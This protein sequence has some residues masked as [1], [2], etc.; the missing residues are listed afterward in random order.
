MKLEDLIQRIEEVDPDDSPEF[1][2]LKHLLALWQRHKRLVQEAA[3]PD[4]QLAKQKKEKD[5]L[6]RLIRA[7]KFNELASKSSYISGL[8]KG[9]VDLD[10]PDQ[11]RAFDELN[12]TLTSKDGIPEALCELT[13]RIRDYYHQ[14]FSDSQEHK[15]KAIKASDDL[16]KFVKDPQ[17]GGSVSF[18]R[19]ESHLSLLEHERAD[20]L[21]DFRNEPWT[22]A[23]HALVL[24][25][26]HSGPLKISALHATNWNARFQSVLETVFF[27][28]TNPEIRQE[29]LSVMDRECG[30]VHAEMLEKALSDSVRAEDA[31]KFIDEASDEVCKRFMR[32]AVDKGFGKL[33]E[34]LQLRLVSDPSHF[35]FALKKSMEPE[36]FRKVIELL[37]PPGSAQQKYGMDSGHAEKVMRSQNQV[38]KNVLSVLQKGM[39]KGLE[40]ATNLRG[41]LTLLQGFNN[42]CKKTAELRDKI[43][44][45]KLQD[46]AAVALD[47]RAAEIEAIRFVLFTYIYD[48]L[49]IKG[50]N[51]RKINLHSTEVA[52]FL[53]QQL[54]FE[55]EIGKNKNI[56]GFL[57]DLFS[58]HP[59]W[60]PLQPESK[61]GEREVRS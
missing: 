22:P 56:L 30:G 15:E 5:T 37:V 43:D 12:A 1:K 49:K 21:A 40:T 11:R 59:E 34:F 31:K 42:V 17:A 26:R 10:S 61:K 24:M 36:L 38:A 8:L 57:G 28:E 44:P 50:G 53:E 35:Y 25:S 16:K 48:A 9:D 58:S 3:A 32:E 45:G 2:E 6:N 54:R 23:L 4:K 29:L 18:R 33:F 46:H 47:I 52:N 19:F 39:T 51:L 20:G 41:Y 13:A 60:A 27:R 14:F 55:H 7:S